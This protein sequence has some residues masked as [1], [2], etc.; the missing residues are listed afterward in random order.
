MG[1]ILYKAYCD[2]YGSDL[3]MSIDA[4]LWLSSPDAWLY[5]EALD[6]DTDPLSPVCM[7]RRVKYKGVTRR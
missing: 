3:Q 1:G 4:L 2:F 6:L 5:V 7:G